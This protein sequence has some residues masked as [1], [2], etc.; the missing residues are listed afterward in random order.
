MCL[1]RTTR[2]LERVKSPPAVKHEMLN[3]DGR[4]GMESVEPRWEEQSRVA[5]VG[6]D[7]GLKRRAGCTKN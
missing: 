6:E 1:I 4:G 2:V 3:E 7:A 5:K